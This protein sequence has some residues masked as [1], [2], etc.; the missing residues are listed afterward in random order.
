[1]ISTPEQAFQDA[2]AIF[3]GEGF[4]MLST[5]SDLVHLDPEWL[6]NRVKPIADH[7]LRDAGFRDELVNDSTDGVVDENSD[8]LK[9]IQDLGVMRARLNESALLSTEGWYE[10]Y[11][12]PIKEA[13]PSACQ[14]DLHEFDATLTP[15]RSALDGVLRASYLFQNFVAPVRQAMG[16]ES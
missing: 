1:M 9:T 10:E 8:M 6:A 3:E 12:A 13:T 5:E 15:V 4:A 2:L 11:Y 16:Y 7:R 14:T